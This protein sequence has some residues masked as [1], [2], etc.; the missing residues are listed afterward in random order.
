MKYYCR[1][2]DLEIEVSEELIR[3]LYGLGLKYYPA[4]YGG[5]LVGKYSNDLKIC[6]IEET[7]V[8]K[9]NRSSRYSFERGKEGLS[10][11]LTKYYNQNPQLIYVGEWHTHP[12]STPTPS[13]TDNQAMKEIAE[14]DGVKITSPILLILGITRSKCTVGAYIQHQK[15][16]YKYEQQ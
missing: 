13:V 5:I 12:D 8:P 10:Q 4:E 7:I 3:Q 2:I 1:D 9:K 11:K 14:C 16:L 6:F 15:R